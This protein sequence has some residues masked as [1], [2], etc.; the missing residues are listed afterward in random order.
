M[1]SHRTENAKRNVLFGFIALIV[2]MV[3]PFV[4]RTVMIYYMGIQYVG[5][6]S[7][8][9]SIL[10]VLNLAE[11]GV[12]SAITYFMYKPVEEKDVD[13][14]CALMN[15]Y[16]KYY[17]VIGIAVLCL[18]LVILPLV[19]HL[20]SGEVPQGL[21]VFVLYILNLS[22]T[23]VSYWLFA[24]K[25]V[26]IVVHQRN[27]IIEK[28]NIL[29]KL[30]LCIMQI[31]I[32]ILFDNYYYYL[33]A[34]IAL[35]IISNLITAYRSN[36]MFPQFKAHGNLPQKTIKEINAKVKAL[37]TSKFGEV[38]VTS[39][40]TIIISAFLGLT[41]LARYNNYYYIVTSIYLVTSVLIKSVQSGI[42]NSLIVEKEIDKIKIFNKFNF[43]VYWIF[44]F[45]I[46]A[47]AILIQEF[48]IVWVGTE[49]LIPIGCVISLVLVMYLQSI[50]QVLVLYRDASALWDVDKYRPLV[51][52][53]VN[54][55]LNLLTVNVIGLYGVILSTF[56]SVFFVGYPWLIRNIF[57][58]VL[59][60]YKSVYIK[61]TINNFIV[62]L[63]GSFLSA[64]LCSFVS[65]SSFLGIMIKFAIICI[66]YNTVIIIANYNRQEFKD[67]IEI[68]KTSAHKLKIK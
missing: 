20:I 12:G 10:H 16:K 4:V 23:V 35:Q 55:L 21:N 50:N 15:L 2:Q 54:L 9:A 8:F 44:S 28:I 45:M 42:G 19:P 22:A 7:L 68:L 29:I 47:F 13:T 48:I 46:A 41:I 40:D 59:K 25:N 66:V 36:K 27:D 62:F 11:L 1:S 67:V 32:I 51:T 39:V 6:S 57:T 5:L 43:I 58:Y 24:Y 31:T 30:L 33:L 17:R 52:A 26:V 64:F 14:I 38:I 49:N 18:G 56:A 34:A 53:L 60:S 37:F 65:I 61:K 63:I 3:G